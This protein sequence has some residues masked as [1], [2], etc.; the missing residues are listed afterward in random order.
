M[1]YKCERCK[2]EGI[3]QIGTIKYPDGGEYPNFGPCPDCIK[4]A[5]EIKAA[6]HFE[7]LFEVSGLHETEKMRLRDI[8]PNGVGTGRNVKETRNL[9]HNGAGFLTLWGTSGNGKTMILQALVFEYILR[10]VPAAYILTYHMLNYIRAA[11]DSNGRNASD[12]A[13]QRLTNLEKI[14]VLCI[15]EVDKFPMTAWEMANFSSIINQRSRGA[16]EGDQITVLAMNK[17]PHTFL[18]DHF[19][20]RF[21]GLGKILENNDS[22]WRVKK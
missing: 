12:S 20:S 15:D 5:Q 22:D 4:R 10:G 18:D 2:D 13:I 16:I 21:L 1:T 6:K 9:M 3:I 19:I 14:P 7:K 8:L 11:F 17:K